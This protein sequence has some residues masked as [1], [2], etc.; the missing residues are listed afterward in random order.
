MKINLIAVGSKMPAWVEEGTKEY[1]KRLPRNFELIVTEIALARRSKANANIEKLCIQE[2][3]ALLNAVSGNQHKVALDVKGKVFS[4]EELAI[5]FGKL[6][7]SGRDISLLAGGP[8]GLSDECLETADEI[9][10]LSA[11]TMP[12]T[13]V[14][15]VVAEQVYRVWSVLTG[16]PYHR[17]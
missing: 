1:Q 6:M 14:R 17:E 13:L 3:K 9:W 12:H 5:K 4:T 10:S 11:L 8:D 16:H 7:E 15:I 2:G